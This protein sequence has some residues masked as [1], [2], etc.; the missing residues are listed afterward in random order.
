MSP[1]EWSFPFP[2]WL[3]KIRNTT[4]QGPTTLCGL[5]TLHVA[6]VLE[7]LVRSYLC[8]SNTNRWAKHV[9]SYN[10]IR[11]MSIMWMQLSSIKHPWSSSRTKKYSIPKYD[12]ISSNKTHQK[13]INCPAS[14]NA[15]SLLDWLR[16]VDESPNQTKTLQ[17]KE[18]T[19]WTPTTIIIKSTV[20]FQYLVVHVPHTSIK[21]LLHRDHEQLPKSLQHFAAALLLMHEIWQSNEKI[22]EIYKAEGHKDYYVST[23]VSIVSSLRDMLYL[24]QKRV[25]NPLL[26]QT[27]P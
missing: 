17:I 10:S 21:E 1:Y 4:G 3:E 26:F 22:K 23:I 2:V 25:S 18:H 5:E 16:L 6:H 13:Y 24:W 8:G 27:Q 19:S 9:L 15:L 11:G 7:Q 20:F 12:T 14:M